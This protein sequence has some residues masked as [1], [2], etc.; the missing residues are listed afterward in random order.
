MM[1]YFGADDGM[2]HAVCMSVA[3]PCD[4]I[5]RELWAYMPR[6]LLSTV[7]Y[8]T[9]RVDGSPHVIDSFGDF[10]G[11]GQR[12]WSTLMFFQTGAG[13]TTGNDRK[14][15]VY[16]I[17]ISDPAAPVVIFEYS[18]ADVASRSS[19][20]LGVGLTLAAGRVQNGLGAKTMV[21]AQTNNGGTAGSGDVVVAI[22]AE[23]GLAEWKAGYAFTTSL[24][25]GGSSIPSLTG[26]PGGTVA[27]DRTGNGYVT[28]VVWG[29]LY[30]DVWRADP[31]TGISKDGVG[32]PLFRFSTDNHP[33]GAKP[34]IYAKGTALSQYAVITT[35]GYVD[36][37]PS[38]TNWSPAGTTNYAVAISMSTPT[39]DA[40]INENKGTP[41]IAWKFAFGAGEK[42]SP[43]PP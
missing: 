28:D 25:T 33:I 19:F 2:M 16:G 15:A 6:T 24:R 12:K 37:Y 14:P 8:N 32:K 40:T 30:G 36:T 3:G 17:D 13:D 35:G 5:G 38:D 9:G 4:I 27:L 26:V 7:R 1:A 41:D 11:S 29:T 43:R 20:E 23:T 22:N 31:S 39:I 18:M 10:T 42:A 34:A 21:F